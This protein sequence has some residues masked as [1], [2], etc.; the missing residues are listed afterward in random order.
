MRYIL[1]GIFSLSF[2]V[3]TILSGLFLRKLKLKIIHHKIL[4]ALSL[5]FAILHLIAIYILG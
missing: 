1:F 5:I 4:A 3:I 2:L